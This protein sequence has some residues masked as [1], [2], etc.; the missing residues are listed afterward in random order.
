MA[1]TYPP[2]SS[3]NSSSKLPPHV[4]PNVPPK[5]SRNARAILRPR[6]EPGRLP[7]AVLAVIFHAAFFALIVFGVSWQVKVATP[8]S[9][10]LW[11][12]LPALKV[13]EP[14]PTPVAE[15]EPKMPE[16]PLPEPTLPKKIEPP[17]VSAPTPPKATKADIAL[18]EKQLN[19][20]KKLRAEKLRVE[21]IAE[22]KRLDQDKLKK[23][24][25]EKKAETDRQTKL[26]REQ[27]MAEETARAEAEARDAASRAARNAAVN[28]YA[29]KVSKLI[30]D[31][32][33]TPETVTGKPAVQI[34]VRLLTTGIVLDAQVIKPSGNR[35]YDESVER[36]INGIKQWPLPSDPTIFGARRELILNIEHE[37]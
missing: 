8:V 16:N 12:S 14:P 15:L 6:R 11:S 36:A 3:P 31:R 26:A 34:R 18:K 33:R 9:A 20:E 29:Q 5:L 35:V 17:P 24:Q 1:A 27:K 13:A 10:E 7:A 21:K 2:N 22:Q 4:P 23:M 19:D 28:D 32:A 30:V 25:S 37:R